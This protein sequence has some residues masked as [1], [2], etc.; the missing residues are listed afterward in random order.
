MMYDVDFFQK[1]F[2]SEKWTQ[3][4]ESKTESM[5]L[6]MEDYLIM[7][8]IDGSPR[9]TFAE[10]YG[11]SE[12]TLKAHT[13]ALRKSGILPREDYHKFSFLRA[14]TKKK[15][16]PREYWVERGKTQKRNW[17]R[18]KILDMSDKELNELIRFINRRED[19]GD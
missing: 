1:L 6:A 3:Y 8:R 11:V 17:I 14:E 12:L 13:W 18:D 15:Q 9:S 5:R 19:D 2:S 16:I 7:V 4:W 10:K